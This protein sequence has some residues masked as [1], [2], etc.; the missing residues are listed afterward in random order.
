MAINLKVVINSVAIKSENFRL[1]IAG[2]KRIIK[3][4][5]PGI[6]P[7]AF[8]MQSERDTTS[9]HTLTERH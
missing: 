6:E 3:M 7:G 9:P 8:R 4:D 5:E 1:N 2:I